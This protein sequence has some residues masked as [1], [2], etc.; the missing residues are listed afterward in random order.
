ML[1]VQ[2]VMIRYMGL[3]Y[4]WGDGWLSAVGDWEGF[5]GGALGSTVTGGCARWLSQI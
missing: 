1:P 3:V 2:T 4:G 5:A